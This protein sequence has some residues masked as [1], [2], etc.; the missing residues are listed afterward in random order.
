M[1]AG[2]SSEL[3]SSTTGKGAVRSR[4]LAV[5]EILRASHIKPWADCVSD[6]ERL[7][8]FNGFL[9]APHLDAAFDRGFIS[10]AED[11]AVMISTALAVGAC[12]ILGL[13]E[14]RRVRD[15]ADAHRA[16]LSWYREKGFQVGE[17]AKANCRMRSG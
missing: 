9:L 12:R 8:V 16:Y 1:S 13:D 14:P 10:V 3:A 2:T 17:L 15:L 6:A 11:G 5:P 7:D 4:C